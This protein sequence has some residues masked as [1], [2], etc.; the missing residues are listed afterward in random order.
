M[1]RKV[2]ATF[3]GVSVS[4]VDSDAP[5]FGRAVE[6]TVGDEAYIFDALT[7]ENGMPASNTIT[8]EGG[9]T[10]CPLGIPLVNQ[11]FGRRIRLTNPSSKDTHGGTGELV[12]A[13]YI[14]PLPRPE[15][16]FFV[17]IVFTD[18]NEALL[19][20]D[21]SH[22]KLRVFDTSMVEVANV[23]MQYSDAGDGLYI[24]QASVD[25]LDTE[26]RY[27]LFP[28]ISTDVLT[29]GATVDVGE[30]QSISVHYTRENTLIAP[31]VRRT[32]NGVG[33]TE[34]GAT[35][36]VA[37]VDFDENLFSTGDLFSINGHITARLNRNLNGDEEYTDAWPAG[38]NADYTHEDHDGAGAPDAVNPA[39]S[40]FHAHTR[41]LYP[42]EPEVAFPVFA[43]SLGAFLYLPDT[44][45]VKFAVDLV[46]PPTFGSLEWYAPWRKTV[47]VI[48]MMETHGLMPDFNVDFGDVAN[49]S[50]LRMAVF[51]ISDASTDVDEWIMRA[52]GDLS[53]VDAT[54]SAMDGSNN[55]WLATDTEISFAP[56]V[57]QRLGWV[58]E[59]AGSIGPV[60]EVAF[61]AICFYFEP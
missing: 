37:H 49:T 57:D 6:D 22:C 16:G 19:N 3:L 42:D 45:E 15:R 59:R 13:P 50:R 25:G 39:R 44:N 29:A 14:F 60:G 27:I 18:M 55:W 28:I 21:T 43:A 1:A 8:H 52:K 23:A 2:S 46:E 56:D 61:A 58:T 9:I 17:S 54:P 26:S 34:P 40:R 5:T 7:G 30:L 47:G 4:D 48:D 12:I 10:G 38:G 35:E 53:G 20:P 24:G 32:S 36:G 11:Y 31:P 41:S 33:V 51:M